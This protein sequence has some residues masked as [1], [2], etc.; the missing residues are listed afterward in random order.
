ME[1]AP[2]GSKNANAPRSA[3]PWILIAAVLIGLPLLASLA[4]FF[5]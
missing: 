2:I 5:L 4:F 1:N 3:L